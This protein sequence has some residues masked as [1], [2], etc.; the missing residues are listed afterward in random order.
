MAVFIVALQIYLIFYLHNK[1][2]NFLF[3]S[4]HTT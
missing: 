4:Y 2:Q 3:F 1:W